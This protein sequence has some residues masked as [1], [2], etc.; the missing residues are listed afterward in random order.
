M[1]ALFTFD[2]DGITNERVWYDQLS[3]MQQLGLLPAG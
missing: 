2:D 1:A 3:I